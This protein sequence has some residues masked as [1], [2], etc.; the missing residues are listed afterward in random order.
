MTVTGGGGLRGTR[1]ILRVLQGAETFSS[2]VSVCWAVPIQ[3]KI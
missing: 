2:R 1:I 3:S